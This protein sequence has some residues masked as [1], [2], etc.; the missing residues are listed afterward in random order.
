MRISFDSS[1][2]ESIGPTVMGRHSA[3]YWYDDGNIVL[4]SKPESQ[5]NLN[6]PSDSDSGHPS[7]LAGTVLPT[8]FRVHR[9]VLGR[10]STMLK[11]MFS[12]VPQESGGM[13]TPDLDDDEHYNGCPVVRM[14]DT[15]EE[16]EHL[17]G[18]MY[19]SWC[20]ILCFC[21]LSPTIVSLT[22]YDCRPGSPINTHNFIR[23]AWSNVTMINKYD[24]SSVRDQCALHMEAIWPV[25]LNQ[26][27]K[28]DSKLEVLCTQGLQTDEDLLPDPAMSYEI[29]KALHIK[30]VLPAI[31]YTLSRCRTRTGTGTDADQVKR[32]GCAAN[33]SWDILSNAAYKDLHGTKELID[34]S[35]LW[36]WESEWSSIIAQYSA[37][38]TKVLADYKA[39]S[40][41]IPSDPLRIFQKVG[42]T[43]DYLKSTVQPESEKLW[44]GLQALY[45]IS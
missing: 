7:N 20:V 2:E 11:G 1:T 15:C 45:N 3:T 18:C 10:H 25:T 32:H 16:V 8:L 30:S 33:I 9:G 21:S 35:T 37:G 19:S 36:M 44:N 17:L 26:W 23:Q 13:V 40:P 39:R 41:Y 28:K 24:L 34:E 5:P 42:A 12:D 38:T 14:D 27:V 43:A 22:L 6:S 4:S 29:A 31:I